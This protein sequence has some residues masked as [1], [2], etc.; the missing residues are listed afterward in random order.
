MEFCPTCG[1]L[2]RYGQSQF[3]C[4]TCPYI[5]R[6]ERQVEIKKKQ[7]LVKKSIDP[8]VKKDDIPK[9]PETE[10]P[11]P[12]CGGGRERRQTR[13]GEKDGFGEGGG[14]RAAASYRAPGGER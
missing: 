10:A 13:D 12:R 2:L 8:V 5:A 11:C 6:I 9:G 14:G 7:L 4:S 3:F 1:N